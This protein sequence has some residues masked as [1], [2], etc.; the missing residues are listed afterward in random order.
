MLEYEGF[1]EEVN[2]LFHSY[3]PFQSVHCILNHQYGLFFCD[4]YYVS[5]VIINKY[6]F[7]LY[8]MNSTWILNYIY[9]SAIQKL[10]RT[11]QSAEKR[12]QE[13]KNSAEVAQKKLL[14]LRL[15]LEQRDEQIRELKKELE[16]KQEKGDII[17]IVIIPTRTLCTC[18]II[19]HL[20]VCWNITMI[21]APFQSHL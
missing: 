15:H 6:Y 5:N 18:T 11:V 17:I 21:L 1:N 8:L 19:N 3:K 14:P 13:T 12:F 9:F 10:Q 4:N 20:F 2:S 16:K 7:T